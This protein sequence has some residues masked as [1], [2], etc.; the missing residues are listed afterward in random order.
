MTYLTENIFENILSYCDDRIERKQ[1]KLM[2][3]VLADLALLQTD[4]LSTIIKFKQLQIDLDYNEYVIHWFVK[5]KITDL[6]FISTYTNDIQFKNDFRFNKKL[7]DEFRN[8]LIY[9][10]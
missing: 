9:Y 4:L 6:L 7:T 3:K 8:T 5:D 2:I 10:K 1:K